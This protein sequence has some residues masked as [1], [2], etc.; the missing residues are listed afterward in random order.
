MLDDVQKEPD[1]AHALAN[2][3]GCPVRQE[4]ITIEEQAEGLHIVMV[5]TLGKILITNDVG[6]QILELC[7]GSRTTD[8]IVK[9]LAASFPQIS[10]DQI[11][12][13]VNAF[14]N[15]AMEFGAIT[16]SS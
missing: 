4:P 6:R 7:D 12:A 5:V 13:D 9:S 14:V 15:N 3:A 2:R 10:Q 1:R 16:W 8:E 11:A